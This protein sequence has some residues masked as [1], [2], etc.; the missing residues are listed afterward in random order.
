MP[1][2]VRVKEADDRL[3][4]SQLTGIRESCM[5]IQDISPKS[6]DIGACRRRCTR[7]IAVGNKRYLN[8]ELLNKINSAESIVA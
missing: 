6:V 8:T 3:Q 4:R 5:R 2:D 1:H 7:R